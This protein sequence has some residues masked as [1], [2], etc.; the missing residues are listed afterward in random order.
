MFESKYPTVC[1]IHKEELQK[2]MFAQN[3]YFE[4]ST[5]VIQVKEAQIVESRK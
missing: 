2:E 3:S 5:D 1:A 4:G